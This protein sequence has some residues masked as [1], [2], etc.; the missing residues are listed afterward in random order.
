[1]N[2]NLVTPQFYGFLLFL[3]FALLALGVTALGVVW[4]IYQFATKRSADLDA[5]IKAAARAEMVTFESRLDVITANSDSQHRETMTILREL[6]KRLPSA[7]CV[8][9]QG[10]RISSLEARGIYLDAQAEVLFR[11]VRRIEIELARTHGIEFDAETTLAAVENP[12][13]PHHQ[14]QPGKR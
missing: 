10:A 13:P 8:T 7:E 3:I 9:D 2:W 6:E 1:M 11:R 4:T 14:H 5:R 12:P